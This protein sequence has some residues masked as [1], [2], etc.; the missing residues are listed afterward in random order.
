M[1]I[2]VQPLPAVYS[3]KLFSLLARG[4]GFDARSGHILS[5]LHLLILEGRLSVTGEKYVRLVMVNRLED[6]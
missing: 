4:P 6:A 3:S 2:F 5:F 1:W